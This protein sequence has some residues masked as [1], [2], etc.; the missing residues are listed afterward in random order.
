MRRDTVLVAEPEYRVRR[1]IRVN[2]EQAGLA[3]MEA[4]SYEEVARYLSAGRVGLLVLS[5]DL[6][7]VRDG[8]TTWAPGLLSALMNMPVAVTSANAEDRQAVALWKDAVFLLKPFDPEELVE[9]ARRSL[10]GPCPRK[11]P[12][13]YPG[14]AREGA[15]RCE[16]DNSSSPSAEST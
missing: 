12:T 6:P 9:V 11:D 15:G 3:V 8:G 4:T 1:M 16:A 5:V 2:L 10:Q 13:C 14:V 7:G